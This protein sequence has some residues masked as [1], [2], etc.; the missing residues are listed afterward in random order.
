MRN[1]ETLKVTFHALLTQDE[2]RQLE[3]VRAQRIVGTPCVSSYIG[4]KERQPALYS[5][6]LQCLRSAVRPQFG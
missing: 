6:W 2:T 4:E 1:C 3:V 5:A